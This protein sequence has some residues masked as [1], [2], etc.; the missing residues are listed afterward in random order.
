MNCA[1]FKKWLANQAQT[2]T[3]DRAARL[4]ASACSACGRLLC[5]DEAAQRVLQSA[6]AR[7]EAPDGL[8]L[9]VKL[10]AAER[11]RERRRWRLLI[12][13]TAVLAC[14]CPLMLVLLQPF[15][16]RLDSMEKVAGLAGKDH[17]ETMASQP[18]S[19][20]F[21]AGSA[22][23]SISTSDCRILPAEDL[24]LSGNRSPQRHRGHREWL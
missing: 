8:R 10:I 17:L 20:T 21:L 2:Q 5:L 14:F 19:R 12:I 9:S 11:S 24:N 18:M 1:E 15:S 3:D 23:G 7:V 16:P 22:T 13:P 4:H 6:L